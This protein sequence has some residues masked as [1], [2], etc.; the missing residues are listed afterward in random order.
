MKALEKDRNRRYDSANG[1]AADVLRYLADEPVQACPPSAGYRLRKFARRNK[2]TLATAA[3]LGVMLL[4][5]VGA[6]TGTLGWAVRDREAREQDLARKAERDLAL[7]EQAVRQ[8]VEQAAKFRGELHAVLH[9]PG[10]V[11]ELLNQ[12]GR[13]DFLIQSAQS[14]LAQARRSMARAETRLSA[15]LTQAL[16][17]LEEQLSGD[18]ADRLLALRLEKISLDRVTWVGGKIDYRKSAGEYPKAFARFWVRTEDAA[19]AR[20]AALAARLRSSPINEQ[21]VA[22]LDDWAFVAVG[23]GNKPLAEDLLAVARQAAPDPGWGD[24][25]RQLEVWRDQEAIGKLVAETPA[26]RLSPQMLALVGYVLLVNNSPLQESWLRRAQ[27]QYPADF[28]LN[29]ALAHALQK[30]QPLEAAGFYRVAL[31]IRPASSAVY[32]N[33]GVALRDQGKP[34]EAIA[35]YRKAIELDPKYAHAFSNLGGALAAQKKLDEAI[36]CLRTAVKL[37][38]SSADAFNNL[39]AALVEQKKWDEAITAYRKAIELD[40]KDAVVHV[41]LGNALRGLKKL[42]EAVVAYREAVRL[43]PDNAVSRNELGNA[44]LQWGKVDEA[45]AEYRQVIKL[46]P[47]LWS[48]HYNLGVAHY[49]AGSLN[50][51]IAAFRKALELDPKNAAASNNLLVALS[52]KALQFRDMKNAAGC[53]ALAAERETLKL[54]DSADKLYNAAFFRA[55]CA[56]A[57]LEDPKTPAADAARLAREQ[58]DLAMAWLH[59]AVAAGYKN[60]RHMKQDKDLDALRDREDFKK[61]L[62]ELEN[63]TK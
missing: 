17:K 9:K 31:A 60:A 53:L 16:H 1:F 23:V 20:L 21:L 32:N 10:G 24:R 15:D 56:S 59:K 58:A 3:L 13:W 2:R 40:P 34:D 8:A 38:P 14:E 11:Q 25:L 51:A 28:W 33:L 57:I 41:N 63:K 44:L 49:Q 5:A 35:A 62:A 39:G 4:A 55:I 19:T 48:A 18:E 37:D 29:F 43:E 36:E 30:T 7:T 52:K 50:E 42:D 46:K 27:V 47:D 61:L 26:D 6:V 54:T 22:A 45:I 12:P